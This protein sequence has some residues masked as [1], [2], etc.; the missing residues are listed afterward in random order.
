MSEELHTAILSHFDYATQ[1]ESTDCFAVAIPAESIIEFARAI[2]NEYHFNML[3]D[4]TAIDWGQK[5]RPRFTV[6]YHLFSTR[7]HEYLRVTSNCHNENIPTMPSVVDIWPAANWHERE[8][9]DMF[10]IRFTGH[11]NLKRILMWEDYPYFP[12]RKEFPLAG[13]ETELPSPDI[14]EATGAKVKTAPLMGGPFVAASGKT[15]SR[16]EPRSTEEGPQS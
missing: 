7:K 11:P 3:M 12:L 1:R 4:V 14:R 2:R 6:V 10:G 15:M 9:Y 8:T 16:R 5:N 13:I